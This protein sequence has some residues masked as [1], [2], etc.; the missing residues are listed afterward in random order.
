MLIIPYRD[1]AEHAYR[2]VEAL[3]PRL[4]PHCDRIL[5]VEQVPG[6]KFNRGALLN[7]GFLLAE[8]G[9]ERYILHDVDLLPSLALWQDYYVGP[10][11]APTAT[12]LVHIGRVW[13]RY[14]YAGYF[15]GIV[16]T[17]AAGFRMA[18]GYHTGYW[19]WGGED[20]DLLARLGYAGLARRE[21][22]PRPAYEI[23]DLEG[24]ATWAAK[25]ARLGE[26]EM[27]MRKREQLAASRRDWDA[28]VGLDSAEFEVV[29]R[30]AFVAGRG[31]LVVKMQVS[32][33]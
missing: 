10:A 33:V 21:P 6:A 26:G 31:A 30:P 19:G 22:A 17:T 15:G 27:N 28:G 12:T 5:F 20:D 13:K 16:S 1:R 7:A 14:D 24:C 2:L 9:F 4:R 11:G 3:A 8:G 18:R 23:E 25:K 29:G 32:V